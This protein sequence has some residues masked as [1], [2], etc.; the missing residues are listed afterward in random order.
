METGVGL[1]TGQGSN[2]QIAL[3][4]SRDNGKTYGPEMWKTMGAIGEYRTRVEWHRLGT[5]R[6]FTPKI[7]ISDPVKVA[8]VSAFINPDN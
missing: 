5:T 1:T 6:S 8:F 7:R 3:S 2:P 4:V